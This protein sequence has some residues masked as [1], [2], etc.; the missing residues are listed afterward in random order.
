MGGATI[1]AGLGPA[2]DGTLLPGAVEPGATV[3]LKPNWVLHLNQGMGGID[4][5]VTNKALVEAVLD[6]VL[7]ADPGRVII[8]DAPIQGCD[9]GSIAP[10]EWIESLQ[11]RAAVPVD[12]VDLRRT[13][14]VGGSVAAGVANDL[15]PKDRYVEFDLG[16]ESLLEPISRPPGRFRVTN[17][18]PRELLRTHRPGVHRYLLCREAFEADVIINMPKLKTHRKAGM[19]GALKNLVGLN[20]SKD[21]LPHHRVGGTW[22]GGDCYA[23]FSP[24]RRLAEWCLD[25]ANRRINTP[26]YRVWEARAYRI[27]SHQRRFGDTE[28]EGGWHGNDT[29]WRMVLDLNRILLY[30]RLDGTMSEV[31]MRQILS[32]TDAIVAGQGEGP[33]APDPLHLGVITSATSSAYAD[34]LHCALL[35]LDYR[36]IPQVREAFGSFRYP[37]VVGT[38]DDCVVS[39][40]EGDMVLAEAVSRYGA[41]ARPPRGWRGHVE[42]GPSSA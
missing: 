7:A 3:L 19:T 33:L 28:I 5:M 18:D 36:R 34:L 38:P 10:R 31:P 9:F 21:Y 14:V 24:L 15:R 39:T 13:A 41:R 16:E 27:L 29:T 4:C 25:Q 11:R 42:L 1:G 37:L 17:Y 32:I 12:V 2:S 22:L 26:H 6:E 8:A 35:G 20:G 23:G 40:S 30:G